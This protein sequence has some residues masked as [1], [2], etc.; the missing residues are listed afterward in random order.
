[1]Q[2]RKSFEKDGMN[3]ELLKCNYHWRGGTKDDLIA[4]FKESKELAVHI[5]EHPHFTIY[6]QVIG[7]MICDCIQSAAGN[8]CCY[9]Y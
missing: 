7:S 2:G 4:E 9:P 1:M 5:E 8:D 3:H 6:D